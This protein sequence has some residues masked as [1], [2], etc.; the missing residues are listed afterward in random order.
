M[1]PVAFRPFGQISAIPFLQKDISN[2][3]LNTW[4]ISLTHCIIQRVLGP[5][6]ANH[7]VLLHGVI[8]GP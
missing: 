4:R 8:A 2:S 6:I 7:G 3:L 1:V 5:P